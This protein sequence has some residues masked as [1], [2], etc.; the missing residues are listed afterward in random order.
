MMKSHR[1]R[2]T[3]LFLLAIL[4]F[5]FQPPLLFSSPFQT[6]Y[7][8]AVQSFQKY[9]DTK[10][11]EVQEKSGGFRDPGL[12]FL[13]THGHPTRYSVVLLHGLSDSPYFMRDIADSLFQ[14]G[15][16][17]VAPL[18]S[19]NGTDYTDLQKVSLEDWKRD[20]DFGTQTASGLG[21]EVIIGGLSAGG[22]LAVD[23]A[24]RH[25][26]KLKGLLLFSPALSFQ[27]KS[28]TL[29]CWFKGGYVGGKSMDVPIRYRKISN[30]G[31]CQLYHLVQELDLSPG[32]V[33]IP[34]PIFAVLTEYDD[35]IKVQWTIDWIE[36]QKE[37]RDRILAYAFPDGK[38]LLKFK[39]PDRALVIPTAEI[40]HAQVTRK[41]NEY[42]DERNPKFDPMEKALKDFMAQNFSP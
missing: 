17:V 28:A 27:K 41:T 33:E 6:D 12:P 1:A 8:Q 39:E 11:K 32:K 14:Q 20:V 42:D 23:A 38:S 31:I 2:G 7:D 30:N 10:Q 4:L 13:L 19:G 26:E 21:R 36:G 35:V 40:R 37:P 34:I 29:S 9:R 18:L 3:P 22:A 15:Y 25:P 24:K 16:N 5:L